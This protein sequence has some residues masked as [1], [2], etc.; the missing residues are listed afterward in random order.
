MTPDVAF[1]YLILFGGHWLLLRRFVLPDLPPVG[2]GLL[3]VLYALHLLLIALFY[4]SRG[5]GE[6]WSWYLDYRFGEYN[7]AAS[8]A[9]ALYLLIALSALLIALRG[10][11]LRLRLYWLGVGAL[12]GFLGFDEY[13]ILHEGVKNWVLHYA[14]AAGT[15]ALVGFLLLRRDLRTWFLL[16]GG[17]G[18]ASVGGVGLE[19]LALYDCFG[20]LGATCN[21]LPLIEEALEN[22]GI[23]TAFMGVLLYASRHIPPTAWAWSCRLITAGGVGSAV[24]LIAAPFVVPGLEA[25]FLAE[26]VVLEYQDGDLSV[27]GYQVSNHALSPGDQVHVQLYWRTRS[28]VSGLQ[29]FSAHLVSRSTGASFASVNRVVE[30]PRFQEAAPG[31]VYRTS[32]SLN[33][34]PDIPVQNSY[35]LTLTTWGNG[36]QGI[37][38]QPISHSDREQVTRDMAVLTS[39]SVI[40]PAPS[41][42]VDHPVR[43]DFQGDLALTGYSISL[44]EKQLALQ[45]AWENHAEIRE[46]LIQ[47]LHIFDSEG[48]YV[49]S[50][51]RP[52]LTDD[53]PTIDWPVSLKA[54]ADWQVDLP[55]TLPPGEYSL[56]TGLYE[57]SSLNRWPVSDSEGTPLPDGII[58]LGTI[59]IEP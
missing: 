42:T 4:A 51:D 29:G 40:D 18:I 39:L 20:Y 45:F 49:Y 34:P 30:D 47:F 23:L 58:E 14:I 48:N 10:Q 9:A 56:R 15:M 54:R 43:Y 2:K 36:R 6:F 16:V 25:R 13:L 44:D 3:V 22:V 59:Q 21:R 26:P 50:V 7:P 17:L 27:I 24:L 31:T 53:F 41:L 19:M 38:M 28:R 52:P 1:A 57:A 32:L 46:P 12:F 5:W 11:S 33:L 35:W 37:F 55:D 8:Y